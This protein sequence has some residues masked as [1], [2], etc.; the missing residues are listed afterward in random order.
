MITKNPLIIAVIASAIIGISFVTGKF[1]ETRTY[2]GPTISVAGE[3][4]IFANP[5]IASI[6]FGV[7]TGRQKTSQA[8]AEKLSKDMTAI[9]EAV[10]EEGIEDKDIITESLWMNP[11]YDWKEGEQ[12]PRGYEA[13]QNLRVKIRDLDKVGDVLAA[14]TQAGANHVGGVNFTIDN[15]EELRAEARAEAIEKAKAKAKVLAKDLGLNLGKLRGFGEGGGGMPYYERSM[16]MYADGKG[17]MGGGME[18]MPLPAG[19]QEIRINVNLTYE[20]K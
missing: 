10:K 18:S 9:I 15:P 7:Q 3:G 5:D 2:I 13:N 4:R 19:E 20:V 14:A 12:I 1:V 8:A 6:S 16:A 11:A 17:G